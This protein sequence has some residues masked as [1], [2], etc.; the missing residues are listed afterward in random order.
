MANYMCWSRTNSFRVKDLDAFTD[1][2]YSLNSDIVIH[3][4]GNEVCLLCDG[5]TGIP[6]VIYDD[7]IG[8]WRDSN[9]IE[10]LSKHL[11]EDSVAIWE[12][13]GAEKLRYL[14]GVSIAVNSK[15]EVLDV[16]LSDILDLIK[17]RWGNDNVDYY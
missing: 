8:D 17:D 1:W 15:G 2:V 3:N 5:E 7:E 6:D 4:D 13:V 14:A 12:E 10:E 9:W 16:A 11:E